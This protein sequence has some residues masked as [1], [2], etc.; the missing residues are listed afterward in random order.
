MTRTQQWAAGMIGVAVLIIAW[1]YR[2]GTRSMIRGSATRYLAPAA[3]R[4]SALDNSL[5]QVTPE[6]LLHYGPT[7]RPPGWVAHRLRYPA[8]PGENLERLT[9]GAPMAC[10]TPAVPKAERGWLFAPPA[11][12]DI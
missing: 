7:M 4:G 5:G 9:H 8:T 11:E 2:R 10:V 3:V 1:D 6:C 12:V